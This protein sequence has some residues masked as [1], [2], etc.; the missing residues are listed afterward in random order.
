MKARPG[1]G[2]GISDISKSGD[3][4][5]VSTSLDFERPQA[6]CRREEE[7]PC[8]APGEPD[9][10]NPAPGEGAGHV[11]LLSGRDC[12]QLSVNYS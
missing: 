1:K 12:S 2:A 3:R 11:S 4:Y 7:C 6:R 10:K 5:L 8:R 9:T